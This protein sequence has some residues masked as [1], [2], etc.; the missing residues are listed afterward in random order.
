MEGIHAK[1][2]IAIE[3]RFEIQTLRSTMF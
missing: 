1:I 2:R 3:S